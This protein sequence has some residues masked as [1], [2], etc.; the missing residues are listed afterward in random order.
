MRCFTFSSTVAL[1]LAVAA[2]VAAQGWELSLGF[3]D[4]DNAHSIRMSPFGHPVAAGRLDGDFTVTMT[5]G[6]G[7]GTAR[8]ITTD[9]TPDYV[10]FNAEYS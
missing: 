5:V 6:T 9:L 4:S 10:T 1:V 8:V 2:P 3:S 7:P